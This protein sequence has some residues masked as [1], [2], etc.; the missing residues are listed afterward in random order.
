MTSDVQQK[1]M[2]AL[3]ALRFFDDIPPCSP[4]ES[5]AMR[6][7]IR[8]HAGQKRKG[9]ERPYIVHPK[10]VSKILRAELGGNA[11]P[12]MLAGAWLHD[13]V[14]DTAATLADILDE[15]GMVVARYVDCCT[16]AE[17]TKKTL[18]RLAAAPAG[19]K[20]IK[21][22][23]IID[24]LKDIEYF[25]VARAEKYASEKATQLSAMVVLDT[26]LGYKALHE[27][28]RVF[29]WCDLKRKEVPCPPK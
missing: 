2:T 18:A 19:A 7:A 8:A 11:T 20:L 1:E 14:E 3:H 13:V 29:N 5:R 6:F 28:G 25:G 21:C 16:K 12:S 15:F 23:D 22:A 17:D 10:A 27:V 24:N 4:L 9:S 26:A